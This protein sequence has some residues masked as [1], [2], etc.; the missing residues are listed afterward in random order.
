MIRRN[1]SEIHERNGKYYIAAKINIENGNRIEGQDVINQ[2]N[3]FI[4]QGII[5]GYDS[6]KEAYAASRKLINN[7]VANVR[8]K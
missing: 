7:L 6:K 5:Q 8:K 1:I 3:S 2:S 4:D